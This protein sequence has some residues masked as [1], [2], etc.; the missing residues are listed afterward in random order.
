MS[1]NPRIE[2]MF[3]VGIQRRWPDAT[4]Q[5]NG[6]GTYIVTVPN[7][8]VDGLHPPSLR[9]SFVVPVGFPFACPADFTTSPIP[10]LAS[11]G[12]PVYT[13]PNAD[14]ATLHWSHRVLMWNP[15]RDTLI[16]YWGTIL[17]R[18][19]SCARAQEGR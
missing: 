4:L 6:D 17:R 9:V 13:T 1:E 2:E 19:R 14:A 11:G 7:L 10:R 3:A 5:P 16:N 18:L 8:V 12:L 15:Q